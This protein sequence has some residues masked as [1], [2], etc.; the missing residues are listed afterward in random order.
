MRR[1]LMNLNRKLHEALGYCWHDDVLTCRKCGAFF[2]GDDMENPDYVADPRLVVREME[3]RGEL[4]AFSFYVWDRSD[5]LR[6]IASCLDII[7]MVAIDTSGKLAQLAL[8]WLK[9]QKEG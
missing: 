1:F 9:E 5:K 3:K 2:I 8:D 6:Y 7:R 4:E